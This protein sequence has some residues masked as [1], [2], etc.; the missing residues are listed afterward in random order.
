MFGQNRTA[1]RSNLRPFA[2]VRLLAAAL[3]LCGLPAGALEVI[4]G[5]AILAHPAGRAIVEAGMLLKAGKLAEVK[6]TSSKEARD[7]WSALSAAEQKAEAAE[8]AKNAPEQ[9]ALEAEITRSGV[10]TNYGDSALLRTEAADGNSTIIAFVV[11]DGGKWKVTAGPKTVDTTPVEETAPPIEG[12]AILD[13]EIGKAAL[14]YAK[15]IAA[16]KF[17][18]AA[19]LRSA[20]A[21]AKRAAESAQQRKES[22]AYWKST[23]AAPAALAEQIRSGGKISFVG[24][25][26]YLSV[27]QNVTTKNADG[28]TT[29][30]SISMSVPFELDDGK[31]RVGKDD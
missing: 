8:A 15:E 7:E 19:E 11:L 17:E 21:R 27:S 23:L 31:W 5:K 14:A 2:H 3:A 10:L 22:D 4:E 29:Y 12:A 26:A 24:E 9:K 18:A 16:G 25:K 6:K 1:T 28:S 13:H 30:S 20:S